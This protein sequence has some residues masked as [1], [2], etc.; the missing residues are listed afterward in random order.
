MRAEKVKM[1]RSDITSLSLSL[2]VSLSLSSATVNLYCELIAMFPQ[3]RN[4]SPPVRLLNKYN[5]CRNQIYNQFSFFFRLTETG[6]VCYGL[7]SQVSHALQT[8]RAVR[9]VLQ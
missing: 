3:G 1:D 6:F 7:R 4:K 5:F 8:T 2:S 9:A